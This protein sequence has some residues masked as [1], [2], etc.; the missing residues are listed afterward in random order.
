MIHREALVRRLENGMHR[1]ATLISA[2]AGFGKTSLICQWQNQTD[3]EVTWLGLDT[4]DNDERR[5]LYYLVLAFQNLMP[6]FGENI[7]PVLQTPQLPPIHSLVSLLV[8]KLHHLPQQTALVIDDYHFIDNPLLHDALEFLL[9][10]IPRHLHL[11]ISTRADPPLQLMRLRSRDQLTEIR[12]ADL[13]LSTQEAADFLARELG[14]VL[15]PTHFAL[16]EKRI[17]GWLA[18]WQLAVISL[19]GQPDVDAFVHSFAGDDRY[20]LD[21][22]IEQVFERQPE[23]IRNFLLQT[24]ILDRFCGPLCDAVTGQSDSQE[25]LRHLDRSNLFIHPLDNKRQWYRYHRLFTD[26][27]RARLAHVKKDLIPVLHQ[28]AGTWFENEAMLSEALSHFIQAQDWAKTIALLNRLAWTKQYQGPT[29]TLIKWLTAIPEDILFTDSRL[30]LFYAEYL[31]TLGDIESCKMFLQRLERIWQADPAGANAISLLH[32]RGTI[33]FIESNF[34]ETVSYAS[35]VLKALPPDEKVIRASATLALAIS[36]V[37]LGKVTEVETTAAEALALNQAI[38]NPFG[39]ARCYNIMWMHLMMQGKLQEAGSAFERMHQTARGLFAYQLVIPNIYLAWIYYQWNELEKAKKYI[40]IAFDVAQRTG[41]TPYVGFAHK[42]NAEILSAGGEKEAALAEIESG[43][44]FIESPVLHFFTGE[45]RA[46]RAQLWLRTGNVDAVKSWMASNQTQIARP[47]SFENEHPHLAAAR[48]WIATGKVEEARRLLQQC[49]REATAHERTDSIIKILLL[50]A[51]ADQKSGRRDE[52]LASITT[53][54]S[55]SEAGGYIRLYVDEGPDM[56]GLLTSLS[57]S[58][59]IVK[60]GDPSPVSSTYLTKI[61]AAFPQSVDKPLTAGMHAPD[62]YKLD[63]LSE[64]ELEVLQLI[65]DGLSNSE[66]AEKLFISLNTVKTHTKK[67]N[68]KL[69]VSSRTQAIA[70]AQQWGLI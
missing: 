11:I 53:A 68:Q 20:V 56:Q 42:V 6:D 1:K 5:F 24:S 18:G 59:S 66:I 8:E 23:S 10:H 12:T 37:F 29:S 41:R 17:E 3:R 44:K 32:I 30:C 49:Y 52:A 43:V 62:L 21:Y 67:I 39:I 33:C 40:Q 48:Y 51:I 35:R 7:L 34:S 14:F 69:N 65:K 60:K 27:L 46:Y 31:A 64:R 4:D 38:G 28:R 54:L 70:R 47:P 26:L 13:R 19:K 63:P 22:L 55:L 45:I 57:K 36:N 2:P 9:L 25:N 61:L 50:S 58:P 15:S 16:M